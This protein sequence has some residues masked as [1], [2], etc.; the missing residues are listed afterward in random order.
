MDNATDYVTEL[1]ES[2]IDPGAHAQ[3]LDYLKQLEANLERRSEELSALQR[4]YKELFEAEQKKTQELAMLA[5]IGEGA[6]AHHNVDDY[7]HAAVTAMQRNFN[8]FDVALFLVDQSAN[9]VALQSQS[10]GYCRAAQEGYRQSLD[11]GIVGWAATTGEALLSNNV[12]EEPRFYCAF[13]E[14]QRT[15][16]ELSVPIKIGNIVRGV[17]DVQS[18]KENAFASR[19]VSVLQ[20]VPDQM[21][22]AI[23]NAQLYEQMVLLK[24]FSETIVASLPSAVLVV[25]RELRL[26]LANRIFCEEVGSEEDEIRGQP[27]ESILSPVLLHDAG[28]LDAIR[29]T[30]ES[31]QPLW[32]GDVAYLCGTGEECVADVR[33]TP[34]GTSNEGRLLITIRDVTQRARQIAQLSLLHDMGG[35]LQRSLDRDRL[36]YTLLTCI[37]A[38][39]ALGFNRGFVLLPDEQGEN[40]RGEMAVGPV[41]VE[42]AHR[43]WAEV[44]KRHRGLQDLVEAFAPEQI[45]MTDI[46]RLVCGMRFSLKES[47]SAI[48]S[49]VMRES[50]TFRVATDAVRRDLCYPYGDVLRTQEFAAAPLIAGSRILGVVLADNAFNQEPIVEEDLKLL[51]TLCNQ[52]GLAISNAI[53]HA[54]IEDHADELAKAY[55]RLREAH[56]ELVRQEKLVT[57]GEMAARVSHEIRNPLATIGGFARSMLKNPDD[58]SRVKSDASIIVEEVEELEGILGNM[59][60]LTRPSGPACRLENVNSIVEHACLMA[61]SDFQK[62]PV[63]LVKQ[64]DDYLPEVFVDARQIQQGLL[65]VIRNGLQAMPE[66][67]E[68]TVA[69][70]SEEDGVVVSITDHGEG[71]PPDVRDNIFTPFYTTKVQGTGLGLAVTRKIMDD[72]H[73]TIEAQSEEGVGTT[74]ILKVPYTQPVEGTP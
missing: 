17:I 14:E 74:F 68:L 30:I 46:Q 32:L 33:L 51:T 18:Q 67:G 10:G 22:T 36:L 45:E 69:T 53:A 23:E 27:L 35:L 66:G 55:Q 3:L 70:A 43:I 73:G 9:E 63:S 15:Q 34:L 59:L 20:T 58:V 1:G 40:L 64:L 44:G 72:H 62:Y 49:R 56:Q 31:G 65:N 26:V 29:Q 52:A 47:P 41:T 60:D 13:P 7:I 71:I 38:G 12:K 37:T 57:V 6:L 54:Q 39:P 61:R 2:G 48:L 19:D 11:V 28:L 8:Y 50:T 25:D 42:E 5:E 16:S 4:R 21:A 24:R